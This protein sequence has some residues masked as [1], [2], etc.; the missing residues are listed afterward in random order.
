MALVDLIRKVI[1]HKVAVAVGV[2]S[3]DQ[4][5]KN[6][7]LLRTYLTVL[8]GTFPENMGLVK[9]YS[10][11]DYK[12]RRIL[13]PRNAAGVFLEIFQD[14]VYEQV[15]R[16]K[17][18]DIVLDIGAYVGMFTVKASRLVGDKGKV[19]AVE[20]SPQNYELLEKNC[21]GLNNVILVKKAIMS[22][23]GTGKLYYAKSTASNSLII[24]G[25]RYVEVRTIKLDDLMIDLGL[26]KVDIIKIDAEGAEIDVLQGGQVVLAN[27]TRLAIAAYHTA[28]NGK[29]E[30]AQVTSLL[31]EADYKVARIRGLRSYLYA[32]PN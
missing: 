23:T 8:H 30:I 16:P 20:P 32:E 7:I 15:W 13:A 27:G 14:E 10:Y 5:S 9:G 19:I 28:P 2:W 25:E 26:D 3:I 1:P 22:K 21:E 17:P 12:G 29:A 31:Q 18:G 4:A 11:Y 6:W 24:R